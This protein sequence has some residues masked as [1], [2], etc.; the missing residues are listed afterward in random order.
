M[1]ISKERHVKACGG[2]QIKRT[3]NMVMTVASKIEATQ[4][5]SYRQPENCLGDHKL[6]GILGH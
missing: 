3:Y 1:S 4:E 6:V 2:H 5:K